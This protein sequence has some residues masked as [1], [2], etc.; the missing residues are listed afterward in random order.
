[1]I[2]AYSFHLGNTSVFIAELRSLVMGLKLC[3][4]MGYKPDIIELDSKSLVE[5]LLSRGRPQL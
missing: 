1:M 5:L 3:K 2:F 4:Q